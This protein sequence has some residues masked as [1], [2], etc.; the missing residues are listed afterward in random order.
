MSIF[1][2][3]IL[4]ILLTCLSATA[5]AKT[6]MMTRAKYEQFLKDLGRNIP[7]WQSSIQQLDLSSVAVAERD[8]RK[9]Q[10]ARFLRCSTESALLTSD[11]FF[12]SWAKLMIWST[13]S[14][15][16]RQQQQNRSSC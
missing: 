14:R 2:R 7:V 9:Q 5:P 6:T 15:I 1:G 10:K 16:A 13:A 8:S 3:I 4:A 11:S 12:T